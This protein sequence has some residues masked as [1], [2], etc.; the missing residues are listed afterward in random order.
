MIHRQ[1]LLGRRE[2]IAGVAAFSLFPN[3]VRAQDGPAAFVAPGADGDGSS[4]DSAASIGNLS[5]LIKAVGPGGTVFIL[6][7]EYD[8]PREIEINQGGSAGNPVTITG[9][10]RSLA[11]K[12][13]TI[14]GTRKRWSG[15]TTNASSFGGNT[16][17]SFGGRASNL[18]FTN[19]DF[20]HVGRIFDFSGVR[21]NNITVQNVSFLNVRDGFY[22]SESS[23]LGNVVLQNFSGKG[24]SKKAVRFQGSSHDW[25]ILDCELDSGY[26]HGD[27]FAVGIQIYD[28]AHGLV[29]NG[30]HTINCLDKGDGADDYWNADGVSSELGNKNI[31][32]AN[33]VSS[34]H[35]DGGYDMKSD[36]VVFQN[37]VAQD[38]KRNYRLWGGSPENPVRMENC[39]SASPKS[40]GGI[41]DPYH[42]WTYGHDSRG[43][44]ASILISG[45]SFRGGAGK[46]P[47][48]IGDG[49]N[50]LVRVVGLDTS[51]MGNDQLFWSDRDSSKLVEG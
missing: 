45:G 39:V 15:G 51:R 43:R 23:N 44:A 2:F 46:Y 40:R 8:V 7:A 33:H 21:A 9:V 19:L 49:G 36:G 27:N 1:R 37:V 47:A 26:Q 32:I 24:F 4:W 10:N 34:G 42:L 31:V 14:V 16:A 17:F 35:S 6:A 30:G 25:Q 13:A 48:I 12:K 50:V 38:N 22:T 3:L 5:A 28:R 11:P 20:R 18:L 41:G 29:I